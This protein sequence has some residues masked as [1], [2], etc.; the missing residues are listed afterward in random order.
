M[1]AR[2]NFVPFIY[3]LTV[4]RNSLLDK[5]A[6]FVFYI[7]LVFGGNELFCIEIV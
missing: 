3:E 2:F 6:Y 1:H 5:F 4:F 7:A